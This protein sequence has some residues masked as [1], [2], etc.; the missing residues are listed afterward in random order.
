MPCG[1]ERNTGDMSQPLSLG[2]L[3]QEGCTRVA[4]P[5]GDEKH[6]VGCMHAATVGTLLIAVSRVQDCMGEKGWTR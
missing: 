2:V 5:L 1:V 4:R 3:G 6:G